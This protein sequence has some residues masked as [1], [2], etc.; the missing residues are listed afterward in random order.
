MHRCKVRP[1]DRLIFRDVHLLGQN[2]CESVSEEWLS[3][4]LSMNVFNNFRGE[5]LANLICIL[6]K[7]IADLFT[8][9]GRQPKLILDI[10]GR[11]GSVVIQ[12]RDV[13][14]TNNA[15]AMRTSRPAG[16]IDLAEHAKETFH[17]IPWN[18]VKL[19]N[20]EDNSSIL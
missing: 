9:E 4:S 15:N 8:R 6:C 13:F 12:L 10:E 2:L 18:S 14:N 3:G 19:I 11:N 20:N 17:G 7:Q 16:E 5:G 1:L